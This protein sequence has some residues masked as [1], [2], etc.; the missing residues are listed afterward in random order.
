MAALDIRNF[1]IL[2]E[3]ACPPH[4][5]EA[6]HSEHNLGGVVAEI[7]IEDYEWKGTPSHLVIG[8]WERSV[9]GAVATSLVA[10]ASGVLELRARAVL[11]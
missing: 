3:L 11:G 1:V 9:C 6:N 7:N 5:D 10:A 8:T 4:A 2:I